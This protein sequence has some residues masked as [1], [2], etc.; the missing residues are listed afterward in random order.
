MVTD[1]ERYPGLFNW[2]PRELKPGDTVTIG[3]KEWII[4]AGGPLV[5][6]LCAGNCGRTVHR[7]VEA[8]WSACEGCLRRLHNVEL[9]L[10]DQTTCHCGAPGL[11]YAGGVRCER[12]TQKFPPRVVYQEAPVEFVPAFT[13]IEKA[14]PLL[15]SEAIPAGPKK[16]IK[17][18]ETSGWE[19]RV[20]ISK[21]MAHNVLRKIGEENKRFELE[22]E[23]IS[24]TGWTA[25]VKHWAYSVWY[26]YAQAPGQKEKPT[27]KNEYSKW[28]GDD[29]VKAETGEKRPL[30]ITDVLEY[31]TAHAHTSTKA[32]GPPA[33]KGK[34]DHEPVEAEEAEPVV[35]K[36]DQ[37]RRARRTG[38]RR[39]DHPDGVRRQDEPTSPPE[40]ATRRG[41]KR[42]GLQAG[43][44][45]LRNGDS[46]P[47]GG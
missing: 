32:E 12:H 27:W 3:D 16:L 24:V 15:A 43:P 29:P 39:S 8:T 42:G 34:K 25:D 13:P 45:A 11:P 31:I 37:P 23:V 6:T 26:R 1:A 40:P 4:T 44:R 38:R 46:Q 41:R 28:N 5:P 7:G 33:A 36:T 20:L 10:A 17:L 2:R 21:A 14:R 22:V 35:G 47:D 30:T 19:C 18:L 9:V